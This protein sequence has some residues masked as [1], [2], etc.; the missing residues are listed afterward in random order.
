[1]KEP[2]C[3]VSEEQLNALVDEELCE[4]D[5]RSVAMHVIKCGWCARTVGQLTASEALLRTPLPYERKDAVPSGDF[6]D[7][8]GERLDDVDTV[9]RAT[10]P[11]LEAT[12]SDP[13][14][15]SSLRMGLA[16]AARRAR[17]SYLPH[18][19]AAGLLLLALAFAV[20]QA[21]LA[22]FEGVGSARLVQVHRDA[23]AASAPTPSPATSA[24]TPVSL[25]GNAGSSASN[26]Q[27]ASFHVVDLDG[28]PAVCSVL[29]SA[30]RPV[31]VISTGK[32]AI[33]LRGMQELSGYNGRYHFQALPDG[34]MVMVDV[35]GEMW[36]AA[37]GRVGPHDLLTLMSR[38]P[39][40]TG[41]EGSM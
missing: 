6:W 41:Y 15:F 23:V 18:L 3:P 31:T 11:E 35:S 8:L 2:T 26:A 9:M 13:G 10:S 22:W 27:G 38:L 5:T 29:G 24:L 12:G 32:D 1:M 16:A 20:Q 39:A 28:T 40:Q 4:G 7:R 36:R 33:S 21:G 19:A 37:V 34:S 25:S 30:G 14:V 17:P